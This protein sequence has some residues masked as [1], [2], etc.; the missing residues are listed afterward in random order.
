MHWFEKKN[1]QNKKFEITEIERIDEII[2]PVYE[3]DRTEQIESDNWSSSECVCTE[4][5]HRFL[6]YK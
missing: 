4:D 6:A 1:E 3:T 2:R 5:L